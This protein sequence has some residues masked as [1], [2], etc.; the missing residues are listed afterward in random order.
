MN[1]DAVN[2]LKLKV[3]KDFNILLSYLYTGQTKDYKLL[4]EEICVIENSDYF[5]NFVYEYLMTTSYE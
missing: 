4:M 5:N 1:V 2:N 3:I